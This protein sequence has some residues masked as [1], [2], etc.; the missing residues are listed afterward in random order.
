MTL[1]RPKKCPS[2][3]SGRLSK[4]EPFECKRCGFR[5]VNKKS[6]PVQTFNWKLN[7]EKQQI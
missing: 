4:I 6:D 3:G 7:K 1:R 2:C 5:N